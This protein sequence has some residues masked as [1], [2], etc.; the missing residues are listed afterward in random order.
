MNKFLLKNITFASLF[1]AIIFVTTFFIAIPLPTGYANLGDCFVI[2]AGIILGPYGV[3]AAAIGSCLCDILTGAYMVYAP[4]T[5]IIK[6]IMALLSYILLKKK[7][8]VIRHIL[9]AVLCEA[10]MVGGYFV[11]EFFAIGIGAAAIGS[12]IGNSMQGVVGIVASVILYT[13]LNKTGVIKRIK[14]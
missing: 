11:Y 5:F 1:A 8:T 7:Y 13:L 3:A 10:I 12:V 14:L 6:G 9:T 4:A 2:L